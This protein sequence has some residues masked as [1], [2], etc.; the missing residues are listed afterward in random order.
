MQH[1]KAAILAT[2]GYVRTLQQVRFVIY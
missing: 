2:S 1:H